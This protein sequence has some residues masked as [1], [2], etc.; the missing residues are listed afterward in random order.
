[1]FEAYL[2]R[3]RKIAHYK[4]NISSVEK[5]IWDI[6]FILA[7]MKAQREGVRQEYDRIGEMLDAATRR[8]MDEQDKPAKEQDKGI[9]ENLKKYKERFEP[10]LAQLKIQMDALDSEMEGTHEKEGIRGSIDGQRTIIEMLKLH[11]KSV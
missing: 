9:I 10:D 2:A 3:R 6:E 5:R 7:K 11:M 4:K 8:M 1:M